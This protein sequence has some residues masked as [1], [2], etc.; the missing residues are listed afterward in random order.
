MSTPAKDFL[1]VFLGGGIGSALRFL[2]QKAVTS[3]FETNFPVGTLVVNGVGAFAMGALMGVATTSSFSA[4]LRLALGTGL[5]G[6]FTTYSAFNHETLVLC[7][8]GQWL[9]ASL[10]VGVTM[11]GALFLGAIGFYSAQWI[12]LPK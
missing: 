3:G 4:S 1:W 9:R 8:N 11:G 12:V 7:Q 5:L 6:G 10:Y 2:V